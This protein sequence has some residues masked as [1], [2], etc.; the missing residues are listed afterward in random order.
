MIQINIKS[1]QQAKANDGLDRKHTGWVEGMTPEEVYEAARGCWPLGEQANREK[2]VH[3]GVVRCVIEI[4]RIDTTSEDG[5]RAIVGRPVKA[6]H[7]FHDRWYAMSAPS[8]RGGGSI[9]YIDDTA[10]PV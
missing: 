2:F 3:K 1:W 9:T 5:R 6:G 8:D 10:K 4:D 7:P